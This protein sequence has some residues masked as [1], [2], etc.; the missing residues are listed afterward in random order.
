LAQDKLVEADPICRE[1]FGMRQRLLG[2]DHPDVATSRNSLAVLLWRTGKL[3]EAEQRFREALAAK[4][5][6]EGS[7][8]P[9]RWL[10]S[11]VNLARVLSDEGEWTE[12]AALFEEIMAVAPTAYPPGNP[13]P[14]IMRGYFGEFLMKR[15]RYDEAEEHLVTSFTE[16]RS[17]LGERHYRTTKVIGYLVELYE[18]LGKPDQAAEYRAMLQEANKE[19]D[20][21]AP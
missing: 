2:S 7:G 18:A 20:A 6:G 9:S 3:T 19:Q 12:A 11:M 15:E 17:R 1:V 13:I 21:N 8:I 4:R 14:A 10:P 16:L 5:K